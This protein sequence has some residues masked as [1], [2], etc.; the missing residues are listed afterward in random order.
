M[1]FITWLYGEQ[2]QVSGVSAKHVAVED[3]IRAS[4]SSTSRSNH[5]QLTGRLHSTSSGEET[6]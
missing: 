6:S 3:L 2:N 4:K 5:R 1:L